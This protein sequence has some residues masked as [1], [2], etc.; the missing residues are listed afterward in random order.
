MTEQEN[1]LYA[2]NLLNRVAGDH[3]DH[4]DVGV[5]ARLLPQIEG[6]VADWL[7]GQLRGTVSRELIVRAVRNGQAR[8]AAEAKGSAQ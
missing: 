1:R 3:F 4:N 6:D 2:A 5:V 8:P 7:S